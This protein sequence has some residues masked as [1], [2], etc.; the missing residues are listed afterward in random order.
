MHR[1]TDLLIGAAAADVGHCCIDIVIRGLRVGLQ[2]RGEFVEP[3][4][5]ILDEDGE[6]VDGVG[7][8]ESVGIGHKV[9]SKQA[10]L[11]PRM[12]QLVR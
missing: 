2:Q 9:R 4:D 7:G 12:G 6:L 11:R 3:T 1:L 10:E 5:A 8:D